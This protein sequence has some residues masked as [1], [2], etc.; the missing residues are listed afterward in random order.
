MKD[1]AYFLALLSTAIALGGALAHLF[2][3]PNKIDL[4]REQYF[5]VQQIYQGWWQ[6]AYVLDVQLL[7]IAA[8]IIMSRAEARVF[9]PAVIALACLVA[10]Q[11]V[12]WTFTQPANAWTSN[13]TAQPENWED[14]RRQWEYSH[15]AGAV[16]QL[17]AMSALVIAALVKQR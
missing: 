6:F 12:F 2:A 5:V 10:A 3:L 15:A 8:V 9:W 17:L 11:V 4:P 13:W 1:I 16:F 7:S 14:L